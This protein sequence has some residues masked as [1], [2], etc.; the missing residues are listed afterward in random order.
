[1]NATAP[2]HCQQ[3][4][5]GSATPGSRKSPDL[6]DFDRSATMRGSFSPPNAVGKVMEI[7]VNS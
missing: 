5:V 4:A 3:K 2:S 1:V 7:R 6:T